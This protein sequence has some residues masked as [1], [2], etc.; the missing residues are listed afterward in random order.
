MTTNTI[1]V[2]IGTGKS[3]KRRTDQLAVDSNLGERIFRLVTGNRSFGREA[4][5]QGVEHV[6]SLQ[7]APAH[8]R[9]CFR[10]PMLVVDPT[11]T[12]PQ[13]TLFHRRD[14]HLQ[15]GDFAK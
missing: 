1:L 8:P 6:L 15:L 5:P 13:P 11:L 7:H 2:N 12:S 4:C 3:G 10:R 9:Q 14:K